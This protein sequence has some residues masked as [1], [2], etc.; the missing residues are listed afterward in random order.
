TIALTSICVAMCGTSSA[1]LPVRILTTPP[2][3][4]LVA[5]IS[6]NVAAGNGNFS[7]ATTITALPLKITGAMSETSA[8]NDGSS[9]V[10]TTTT[11]CGSGVVKLKC[12][13]ATGFTLLKTWEYLSVQPAKCTSRSIASVTSRFAFAALTFVERAIS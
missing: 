4:S 3:K 7:D 2:G 9:G 6:A 11:P 5:R 1:R 8:S 13:D 12:D 10:N